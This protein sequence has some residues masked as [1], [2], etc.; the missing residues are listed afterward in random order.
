[1]IIDIIPKKI[2]SQ[3]VLGFDQCYSINC[4]IP[5][6]K[7]ENANIFIL[8]TFNTIKLFEILNYIN[9]NIGKMIKINV[10]NLHDLTMVPIR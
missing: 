4:I 5:F 6:L 1:M 2:I 7:K 3:N 10:N 9:S 8:Q